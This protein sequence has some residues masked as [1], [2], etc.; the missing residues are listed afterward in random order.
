MNRLFILLKKKGQKK[1]LGAIPAR[2]NVSKDKL[3]KIA[4]SQI[5]SG[6]SFRIITETDL[7]KKFS[8]FLIKKKKKTKKNCKRR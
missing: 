5:K 3:S 8:N 6:F 7:K 2:K 1:F 4:R